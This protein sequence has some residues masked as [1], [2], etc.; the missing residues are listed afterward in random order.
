MEILIGVVIVVLV[1][2]ICPK[3]KAKDA[4]GW[5]S[6][7][8]R[9]PHP[10][11]MVWPEP[12]PDNLWDSFDYFV[13]MG[14]VWARHASTF[15]E[16]TV[17]LRLIVKDIDKPGKQ[18]ARI[19]GHFELDMSELDFVRSHL[20]DIPY[21]QKVQSQFVGYDPTSTLLSLERQR[22]REAVLQE[23]PHAAEVNIQSHEIRNGDVFG[24]L[25]SIDVIFHG[26]DA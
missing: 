13:R 23:A 3:P 14:E 18:H 11:G 5:N 1:L 6:G 7:P 8:A 16:N 19:R 21:L 2:I 15:D 22:I 12:S 24:M 20:R 26:L 9:D 10:Y 4:Q 17:Y 25:V